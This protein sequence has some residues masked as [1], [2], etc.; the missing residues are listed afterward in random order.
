MSKTPFQTR[1]SNEW[2]P[3][4]LG[5]GGGGL[6]FL[7]HVRD[8]PEGL[9]AYLNMFTNETRLMRETRSSQHATRREM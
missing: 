4:G 9:E 6:P 7:I 3:A 1:L 2:C 8:L 5:L